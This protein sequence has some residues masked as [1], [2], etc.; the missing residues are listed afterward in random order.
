MK[1][2]WLLDLSI[3]VRLDLVDR[4]KCFR[5]LSTGPKKLHFIRIWTLK[6]SW[7]SFGDIYSSRIMVNSSNAYDLSGWLSDIC[8]Y[9]HASLYFKGDVSF[10][11]SWLVALLPFQSFLCFDAEAILNSGH[12]WFV[13]AVI[14]SFIRT[15]YKSKSSTQLL[16]ILPFTF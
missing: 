5:T 6:S 7:T 14:C 12:S 11:S 15:C 9:H 2:I 3:Q 8:S 13:G 4:R 10:G 1:L 16:F